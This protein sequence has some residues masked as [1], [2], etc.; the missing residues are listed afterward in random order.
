MTSIVPDLSFAHWFL[1]LAVALGAGWIKGV[2]GFAMPM[3][4]ISLLS[5]FLPPSLAL[6]GLM[7]PTLAT[8]GLQALRDG[9]GAA[10]AA[11]AQFRVFLIAAAVMLVV[12]AQ[13][14]VLIPTG[15]LLAA[16]GGPVVL[17]CALQIAGWRGRLARQNAGLEVGIGGMAGFIGG[18]SG[19]WGPPMVAYLTAL[20]TEKKLQMRAQGAAFGLGT[21]LLILAHGPSGVVTPGTLTFSAILTVPA[22]LGMWLGR[23]VQDRIDQETFRKATLWVLLLAG[24]NLL[25]RALMG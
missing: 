15:L 19:V 25:R 8:N 4:M 22:V 14:Y 9:P 13:L 11:V 21:I 3:I 20:G 18:L 10:L 17:F 24:L 23:R 5:S 1:C 12:S 16:I 2:V 7:L 6:A